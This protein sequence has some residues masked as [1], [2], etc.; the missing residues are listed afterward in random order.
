VR[1]LGK[2]QDMT[3]DEFLKMVEKANNQEDEDLRRL[4]LSRRRPHEGFTDWIQREF[5]RRLVEMQRDL[6]RR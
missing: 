3:A 4:Q 1:Q 2:E 6:Y 5:T